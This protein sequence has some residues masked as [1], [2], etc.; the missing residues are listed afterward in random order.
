MEVYKIINMVNNKVYIGSTIYTK[1]HRIF[2]ND[3]GHYASAM[4]GM[5][6]KLYS[7]IRKYSIDNF[8]FETIEEF[9]GEEY[10]LRKLENEYI[11]KYWE[12]IGEELM[13]NSQPSA[14][15]IPNHLHTVDTV[16]KRKDTLKK[17]YG[18]TYGDYWSPSAREK[19]KPKLSKARKTTY[20]IG[21]DGCEVDG[22]KEFYEYL[23][24]SGYEITISQLNNGL[25]RGFAKKITKKYP[26][27]GKIQSI[28][29]EDRAMGINFTKKY[30]NEGV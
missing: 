14:W 7:D 8:K 2:N 19:A 20:R 29:K 28:T 16:N 11:I 23:V 26:E 1:E 21:F 9:F 13:Y 3:S 12:D 22:I 5:D 18:D 10:D 24:D 4:R 15:C 30:M 25:K 27:L 6:G 17:Q